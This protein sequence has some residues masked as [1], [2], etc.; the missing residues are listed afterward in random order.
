LN[1]K[2]KVV[3][4]NNSAMRSQI[5]SMFHNS[6]LRGHSGM[7]VTSKMVGAYSIGKGNINTLD[8][9]CVNA[10]FVRGT[11]IKLT[12]VWTSWKAYLNQM[13]RM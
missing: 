1:S 2:K 13:G 10:T 3:I 5:I 9:M 12:L 11:S 7:T 8:S 6:A 4:G